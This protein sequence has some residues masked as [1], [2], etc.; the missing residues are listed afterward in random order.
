[1]TRVGAMVE[2]DSAT[3]TLVSERCIEQCFR[4]DARFDIISMERARK[5]REQLSD[6]RSY[7]LLVIIPEG[8]EV[9]PSSTNT[10]HFRSESV[11]R[12]ILALAVVTNGAAMHAVSKFYFR[13]YPQSFEVGVFDDEQEAREWLNDRMSKF[14]S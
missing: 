2:T 8:T 1:M 5:A 6:G 3:I 7:G 4:K 13:Y 11:D 12:R 9:Q 10:D 14:G